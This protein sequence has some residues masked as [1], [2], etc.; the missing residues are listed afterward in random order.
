MTI[1]KKNSP[2]NS[3]ITVIGSGVAGIQACL[4]A[5]SAGFKVYLV[6]ERPYVGGIIAQLDKTFP[7]DDCAACMMG[8]KL[9]ELSR[10]PLIEIWAYTEVLQLEG[11]PGRFRL[12]LKQKARAVDPVKCIGCGLCAEK[13]PVK[14]PDPF[15][16]GLNKRK[17]AFLAYPQAVPAVYTIDKRSCL[18][19]TQG[20]CRICEKI[21]PPQAIDFNQQDRVL[22][23][24]SGAVI[25]AGGVEPFDPRLKEELG[26]GRL[27]NVITS[28]EYERILSVA[29][30]S[31]GKIQ[32]PSDGIPP[33]KVAWLQCVGSRDCRMGRDYCSAVCC[34]SA[35]KQA[36]ITREQD[37]GIETTV[38][39]NDFRAYGKGFDRF[40]ERAEKEHQVRFVRSLLSRV[41]PDPQE[42]TLQLTYTRS[43]HLLQE[44]SFDL[45][46]LSVG[47]S[48]NHQARGLAEKIGVGL[49]DYGFCLSDPLEPARTGREGIYVCGSLQGPK[50]IPDSVQQGS[51][52]AA[53]AMDLLAGAEPQEFK[54]R[55]FPEERDV[56]R[57]K[58]RIGVFICHCG[59][60][61]AGVV[62]VQAVADYARSL[63]D[64]TYAVDCMFACSTDQQ[65]LIKKTLIEEGLNRL[66][67]A[68]CTPRTHEPLFRD[69]MRQAGLNPFLFD[70]A[71]IREQDS[72]VHR[73]EKEAATAK[74]KDLV[75]MSVARARLLRPL[76]EITYPV[77]QTA[78]VIGGGLAGLTAAL[79]IAGQ[80][81]EVFLLE[82]TAELG[83]QARNLHY[84]E[85]GA[86]PAA[87]TQALI[88]RV[89]NHPLITILTKARVLESKGA[90]GR[91][92]T[93]VL[94]DEEPREIEH[95]VTLVA[96]GAEE[97]FPD[98]YLYGQ[99]PRV[100][101]RQAFET[102]LTRRPDEA[103]SFERVVM[104]QCVG[105]REPDHPYCSR[106]CC[107]GAV[108]NS[109]KLKGLNPKARVS[110]L[111]RDLR[112]FG[113]RETYYQQARQI[114][115]RFFRYE[116]GQKPEVSEQGDAL[117]IRVFDQQLQ[118]SI[119][120]TADLLVLNTAV[121]PLRQGLEL[122]ERLR[123]PLDQDGFFMEAHPKLRPLD[124]LRPGY[125]VCG[126]A[127]GPKFAPDAITQAKGAAAR[128]LTILSR[129]TMVAEGMKAEISGTFC[130]GCG[131]CERA[132]LF[133]AVAV[134]PTAE[135]SKKAVVDPSLCTGCGACVVACPNGAASLAHFQDDQIYGM[136]R[137]FKSFD[138]QVDQLRRSF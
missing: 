31:G 95:G 36:M 70:L 41:V 47:L 126:L 59:I 37:G 127:Q 42:G 52:A 26:Y 1:L 25:L 34:M 81:H 48:P 61:I 40:F 100:M 108:K 39:Y 115:V 117:R 133:E 103:S 44:A 134:E 82:R 79:T 129:K 16:L 11:E 57:E 88:S 20:R 28:L 121:R 69:T 122:A 15:N 65:E 131:E 38:F 76:S 111:Y 124:F 5:A 22:T 27:P 23:L 53:E 137:V 136:I 80:G 66:V 135:G 68:A 130:R 13:C 87:H 118:T 2:K 12:T 49:D 99:H 104:I 98:E 105:S 83:G 29:G 73:T 114:G 113:L 43:D 8:P 58:P 84:T 120:L 85:S 60:N 19:F 77:V 112:T 51:S 138:L 97:F 116:W 109:L 3:S 86:D 125:F 102:L 107:T 94:V 32:R 92:T 46:V 56:S 75:R 4:D 45:V 33:R 55:P 64:V 101:T 132:C 96:V 14:I 74:A 35:V 63:P 78:L 17:A 67:I 18:F 6:E 50:D 71:N 10:H 62:D 24:E 54:A 93:T 91:F 123:L 9:A 72:W 110:I 21:C 89:E 30:P 119:E 90:C 106:I 128:A 7:T